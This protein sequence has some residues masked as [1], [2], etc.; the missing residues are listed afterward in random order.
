MLSTSI[1]D[2]LF[3]KTQ[4]RVLGLLYGRPD[5]SFYTNDIVRRADM[6]RGTVR[7]ELARMVAAGLLMVRKE[8]N[9]QYYQANPQ[10]PVYA[11]LSG[12]VRKTFGIADEI[13]LAL[14][15]LARHIHWSFAFGSIAD[16]RE[17]AGSDVDLMVIGDMKFADV[18]RVLHPVQEKLGREINPKIYSKEEWKQ[19]L[20]K[21][22][23]FVKD[24]MAS[25][26]EKTE[27][28]GAR[29]CNNTLCGTVRPGTV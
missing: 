17:T 25:P 12:I 11:E 13:R 14:E 27:K 8:G 20:K 6:G 18:V 4:Q 22:D 9:Q 23:A 21:K 1:G 3:T 7:R 28:T 10:C 2:A 29:S 15:P 26:V 5:E 24:V 16:G 19:I